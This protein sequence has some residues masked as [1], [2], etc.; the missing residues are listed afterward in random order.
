MVDM[1]NVNYILFLQQ[2]LCIMLSS[3]YWDFFAA[4][5]FLF[6]PERDQIMN[7][8][9]QRMSLTQIQL[10]WMHTMCFFKNSMMHLLNTKSKRKN[11]RIS[12]NQELNIFKK[13][14]NLLGH[15]T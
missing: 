7:N 4:M 14:V 15:K 1:C 12:N 2:M 5:E 9:Y 3:M 13:V 11:V 6:K 10:S 8:K